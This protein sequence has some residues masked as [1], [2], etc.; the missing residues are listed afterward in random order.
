MHRDLRGMTG[1]V[2][3]PVVF[4]FLA[5]TI[6]RFYVEERFVSYLLVPL[7]VI[8]A[9]GLNDL[10]TARTT[11]MRVFSV[12]YA[13]VAAGIALLVFAFFAIQHARLPR[14]ANREAAAA[15]TQALSRGA[16]PV[17]LNTHHA[18]DL[19][20]YMGVVP[21]RKVVSSRLESYLCTE[22][23]KMGVIFVQQPY[24]VNPVDTA[25]LMRLGASRHVFRQTDRGRRITVWAVPPRDSRTAGREGSA[26][27]RLG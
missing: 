9:F 17:V 14:E 5:L 25:C 22:T 1:I 24:G 2:L 15:V 10:A 27:A 23:T 21:L 11:G 19:V 20:Y 26:P 18:D 3:V 6:S 13:A 12:S 4:T 7:F 8:A 16:R